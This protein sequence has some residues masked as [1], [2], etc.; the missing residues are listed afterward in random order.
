MENDD[1][2]LFEAPEYVWTETPDVTKEENMEFIA[3]LFFKQ[4]KSQEDRK[5]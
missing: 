5:W 4:V 3:N 2:I 1:K